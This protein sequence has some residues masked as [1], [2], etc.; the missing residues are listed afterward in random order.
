MQC[1]NSQGFTHRRGWDQF[2]EYLKPK[3]GNT[4]SNE[5]RGKSKVLGQLVFLNIYRFT[6]SSGRVCRWANIL[7]NYID[8]SIH[9][10]HP[11]IKLIDVVRFK[12]QLKLFT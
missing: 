9:P 4:I 6:R 7:Y 2:K 12:S 11:H 8:M 1:L 3:M 5:T 10:V